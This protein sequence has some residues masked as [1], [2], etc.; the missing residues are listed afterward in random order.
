[1]E[2]NFFCPEPYKNLS[3][4]S[5]GFWQACCIAS[6]ESVKYHGMK[7]TET[8]F[9]DFYYSDYMN[10]LRKDMIE[11]NMSDIVKMTCKQCIHNEKITG[12]SRR[13]QSNLV[14]SK[15]EVLTNG[16]EIDLLR[17]KHIGNLCNAKCV[18]CFPQVS[19]LFAQEAVKLGTY[20]GPVIISTEPTDTYY[21]G[22]LEVLPY[23]KKIKFI[24]GE[25]LFNPL[26][27]EF[28]DWLITNNLTH[29]EIHFTTNGRQFFKKDKLD[30]LKKFK[31]IK[32]SISIDAY[33]DKNFY[34]RYPSKFDEA[35]E[36]TK[37]FFDYVDI[38][39]IFTT[40]SIL[41]IGY[42]SEL[43]EYFDKHVP[44]VGWNCDT[45]VE[46][47]KI[48][49]PNNIP[50]DIKDLYRENLYS[51]PRFD[52]ILKSP[53]DPYLFKKTI[54]FLKKLDKVRGVQLID[55]WPEFKKY[56]E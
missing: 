10:T 25:P 22:L 48:F 41:N 23:T 47:P 21:E 7:I 18:T 39:D 44:N 49:R 36:N 14:Y 45:L 56:Y 52:K 20:E 54:E 30:I 29:L 26:T 1:M 19:S 8:K 9:K 55:Y 43:K 16:F 4:K 24:G 40:V 12:K 46:N 37:K 27:W 51:D 13:T 17:I 35:I 53:F 34:I 32:T 38:C 11:G 2:K 5:Y 3:S 28:I 31:L 50:D 15:E 42:I 6:D 33:G